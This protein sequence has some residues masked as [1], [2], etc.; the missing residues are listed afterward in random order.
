MKK[1]EIFFWPREKRIKRCPQ[2]K[3]CLSLFRKYSLPEITLMTDPG[4]IG[5]ENLKI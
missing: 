3:V 5:W 4:W 1:A 2:T